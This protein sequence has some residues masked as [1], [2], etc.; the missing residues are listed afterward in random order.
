MSAP[1]RSTLSDRLGPDAWLWLRAAIWGGAIA[2]I[3]VVVGV[4]EAQRVG[5]GIGTGLLWGVA[6]GIVAGGFVTLGGVLIPA[7]GG[8]AVSRLVEP[9]SCPPERGF[10]YEQSLVARGDVAGALACYERQI[11]SDP[12]DVA[13]RLRAAELYAGNGN[14]PRKA[15][16]LFRAAR[17]CPKATAQQDLHASN[18]L[19][20]LYL[21]PL[22]ND[23]LARRELERLVERHP[24]TRAALHARAVLER[25]Q[26]DGR[27]GIDMGASV[28][29]PG[30]R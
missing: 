6:G 17:E 15:C 5:A 30:R 7:V 24:S 13:V 26:P 9:R 25:M 22:G 2:A 3:G 29:T 14:D 4:L 20:D 11:A 10:S 18:R 19:I 21:G 8:M 27:R 12:R 28:M 16:E 23:A 1:Y